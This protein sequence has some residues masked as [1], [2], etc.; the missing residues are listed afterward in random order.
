M[1]VKMSTETEP[2]LFVDSGLRNVYLVGV[3]YEV[4]PATGMQSAVIPCL[5][6]LMEAIGKVLVEK[7][8]IGRLD[9]S[10]AERTI[11]AVDHEAKEITVG[12]REHCDGEVV[13]PK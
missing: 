10:E 5:P 11:V 7:K 9:M 4:A 1:M 12:L 2:Y 3:E 13:E 6:N 8:T